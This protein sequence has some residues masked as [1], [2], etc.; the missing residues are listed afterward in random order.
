MYG[1]RERLSSNTQPKNLAAVFCGVDLPSNLTGFDEKKELL[2]DDLYLS[3]SVFSTFN[4]SAFL[5][6]IIFPSFEK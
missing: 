6:V 1:F 2:D 3:K 4:S 5:C